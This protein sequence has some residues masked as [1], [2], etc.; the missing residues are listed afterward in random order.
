MDSKVVKVSQTKS[1]QT[2]NGIAFH[3]MSRKGESKLV[4]CVIEWDLAVQPVE[5]EVDKTGNTGF[6]ARFS[7]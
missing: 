1:N 3:A 7:G 5:N 4:D 6:L 2:E